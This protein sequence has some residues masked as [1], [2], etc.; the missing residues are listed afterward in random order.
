M[1]VKELRI[2]NIISVNDEVK[3]EL[4]EESY[5]INIFEIKRLEDDGDISVYNTIENLYE[6][7]GIHE[8][9]PIELNKEWLFKLGFEN[10]FEYEFRKKG[11]V[12]KYEDCL[13]I[14]EFIFNDNCIEIT[15]V[16]QLQNLYFALTGTELMWDGKNI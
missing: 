7:L 9:N 14:Y 6:N 13:E 12:I 15:N 8:I 1:D 2:G 11:V 16:H 10:D 3:K 4:E 5:L